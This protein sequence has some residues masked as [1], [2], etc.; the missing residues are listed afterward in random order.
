L[1]GQLLVIAIFSQHSLSRWIDA[2]TTEGKKERRKE[3]KKERRKS[4]HWYLPD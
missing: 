2:A 4:P 1:V 3:G